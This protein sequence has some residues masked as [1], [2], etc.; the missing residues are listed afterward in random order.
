M[1]AAEERL[2]FLE[3]RFGRGE[4]TPF[5]ERFPCTDA[6]NAELFAHLHRDMLRYDHRRGRWLEWAGHWWREDTT[7]QVVQRAI[8]TARYRFH[9]ADSILDAKVREAVAVWASRSESRA[10]LD[11]CLAIARSVW[12]LQDDGEAWD[13][14]PWLL[15]VENG[16]VDLRTTQLREGRR[17]DKLT[18]HAPVRFD[19]KAKCPAF[20]S[21]LAKIQPDPEI[22]AYLQ[23][24]AGYSLTGDVGE[25]DLVFFH[26][27][28]ANGKTTFA[29]ALLDTLGRD[30]A[31][32]AA[33][34][35]LLRHYGERHP[36]EVADLD[37]ARLLLSTEVDEGRALAEE[38][39]KQLTGG[40]RL[41]ARRMRQDFYEFECTFKIVLLANHKPTVKGTDLAI[42]RRIKLVPWDVT[43]PP[44]ERDRK[45]REK[46][47][48]E[49]PGVLNWALAGCLDWQRDGM[50]EP[51]AVLAATEA[52]KAESDPLAQ[53]IEDR[54]VVGDRYWVSSAAGYR[55]YQ[56]WAGEQGMGE[57]EGS[58]LTATRFG[59]LIGERFQRARGH[60]GERGYRGIGLL[61]ESQEAFAGDAF[62]PDEPPAAMPDRAEHAE[63]GDAFGPRVTR[64]ESEAP[65]IPVNPQVR[66]SREL[67]RK[68]ASN[69]STRHP[70]DDAS[71][72]KEAV[73]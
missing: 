10:R 38:L 5:D 21:F 50:R 34:G 73:P 64:F 53:F 29:N 6:G 27:S 26:G 54:C 31:R 70:Q 60:G 8:R 17:E 18:R 57:R 58:R 39:V 36:T 42:W 32:Q 69:A 9:Q 41:K 71:R 3:P 12:P 19:A 51:A 72:W 2:F 43:I 40:D 63:S 47:R 22:R 52:Y 33:P 61:Y 45:L 56:A 25:Q 24:R 66:A 49:A 48:R 23:R 16:V 30:Y 20:D 28:G 15:G 59:K 44:Q 7:E 37:G 62:A 11:A 13:A 55:S 67:N 1:M 46:L 14:D 35:L 65:Q 4:E 68:N